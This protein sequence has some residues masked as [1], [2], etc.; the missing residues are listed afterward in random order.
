MRNFILVLVLLNFL[1]FAYQSWILEPENKVDALYI[2][3][4][5]PGLQVVGG[6]QAVA[7]V[8][9]T[10]AGAGAE[11]VAAVRCLRIGP[12]PREADADTVSEGLEGRGAEVRKSSEPGQVWVGHWVQV[13]DQG[14]RAA[15]EKARERLKSGGLPDAY[16]LPGDDFR[17]SLGVFRL[18]SSANRAL[19][20]ATTQGLKTR[21][22]DRYQ[23][24]SNFWLSVRADGDGVV[25]P[26]E[27][28]QDA[29][30]ILRTESIACEKAGF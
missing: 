19:E 6:K 3:Q 13:E 4:D 1:A 15:A 28:L 18:R 17:I 27:F 24:G 21:V 9:V 20:K 25:Q 10:E 29:G 23:P 8:V 16:I 7:T 12:F 11:E 5:Y 30:Q 26:G 22:D 2:E 14:G